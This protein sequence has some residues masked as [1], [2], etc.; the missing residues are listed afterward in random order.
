MLE[1]YKIIRASDGVAYPIVL[2]LFYEKDW[3]GG[4]GWGGLGGVFK[5]FE[6]NHILML[7]A[8]WVIFPKILGRLM[9]DL[10]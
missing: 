3:R 2:I 1:L 7:L 6:N 4:G 10:Y 8:V 5:L 9:S